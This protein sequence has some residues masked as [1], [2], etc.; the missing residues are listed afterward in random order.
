[1]TIGFFLHRKQQRSQDAGAGALLCETY[2]QA[3]RKYVGTG[4]LC[5]AC[6]HHF[7]SPSAYI[8]AKIY[9][10]GVCKMIKG[11]VKRLF[12]RTAFFIYLG[13]KRYAY[14][15][16]KTEDFYILFSTLLRSGMP[17]GFPDQISAGEFLSQRAERASKWSG[18]WCQAL[19]CF[20]LSYLFEILF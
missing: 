10:N 5:G 11:N 15:I 17:T 3:V 20:L 8:P 19:W 13:N 14:E 2:F 18:H 6:Y 16:R 9:C 1:M 12:P 7:D 4:F